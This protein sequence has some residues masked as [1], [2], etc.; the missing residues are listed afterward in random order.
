MSMTQQNYIDYGTA[1]FRMYEDGMNFLGLVEATLPKLEGKTLTITG[2]GITG[3]V[4]VPVFGHVGTMELGL[5]FYTMNDNAMNLLEHRKHTVTLYEADEQENISSGEY[6]QQQGKHV[7][8]VIPKD[9]DGGKVAPF[10]QHDASGTYSVHE[11]YYYIDGVEKM[12]IA[13][14]KSIYR[15][16]GEDSTGDI[17][18]TLGS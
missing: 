1:N 2:A 16:N 5:K 6:R 12:A 18:A 7:M 14:L 15:I 3:E 9:F 10:S 17:L 4:E 8:V 11:W 13:P